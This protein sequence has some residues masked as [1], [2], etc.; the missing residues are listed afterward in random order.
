M[1]IIIGAIIASV[2]ATAAQATT[3][4]AITFSP[5]SQFSTLANPP[6][7]LGWRFDVNWASK[8]TALGVADGLDPGLRNSFEVG[9]W[10]AGGTLIASG[11]V[12][13]GTV[14]PLVSGFRYADIGS[15]TVGP[16]TYFVG[17]LYLNGADT[18]VFPGTSVID[19]A[20]NPRISYSGATY[21]PGGVLASPTTAPPT[22]NLGYFGPN[23]LIDSIPEPQDWVLFVVGFSLVGFA[24]RR[25]KAEA[26]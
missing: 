3:S 15:L 16:G 2:L 12:A 22:P 7:T 5:A 24:A 26:A 23:L 25:R 19:F 9:L 1:R 18:V 6:F 13:N 4:P 8:I 14:A 10:D 21:A 20:V 11:I 17:A